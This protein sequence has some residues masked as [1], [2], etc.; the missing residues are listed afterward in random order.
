M[1]IL[2]NHLLYLFLRNNENVFIFKMKSTVHY[3]YSYAT[4]LVQTK[5][6]KHE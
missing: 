4:K 1:K 5:E 6:Q 3:I 2:N